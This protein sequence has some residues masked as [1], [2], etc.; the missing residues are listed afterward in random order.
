MYAILWFMLHNCVGSVQFEAHQGLLN[1]WLS[2]FV[3]FRCS[4]TASQPPH[5]PAV[6]A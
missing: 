2:W 4:L 5:V 1:D 6:N 3:P